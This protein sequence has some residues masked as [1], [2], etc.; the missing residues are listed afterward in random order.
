MEK[1]AAAAHAVGGPDFEEG[2]YS[3]I[4]EE[5]FFDAIDAA[6]DKQDRVEERIRS[7]VKHRMFAPPPSQHELVTRI[8]PG[9]ALFP[10]I[11]RITMQHVEDHLCGLE[12]KPQLN[13][14]YDSPDLK[15]G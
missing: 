5:E 6:L 4:N 11:D 2:P 1:S 14:I 12:S 10:E 8:S 13:S 15:V 9:H 3:A 7:T